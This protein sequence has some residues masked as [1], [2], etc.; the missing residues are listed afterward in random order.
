MYIDEN[1]IYDVPML[2][3]VPIVRCKNCENLSADRIAPEWNRICRKYGIGKSDYGF[4]DEAERKET[5]D[6]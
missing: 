6:E 5:A 1:G 2:E 4:C 3:F